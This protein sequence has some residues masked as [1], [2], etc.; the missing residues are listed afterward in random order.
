VEGAGKAC[1]S[2][3]VVATTVGIGIDESHLYL[4]P[5][6]LWPNPVNEV[7]MV[8]GELDTPK[9]LT[10]EIVNSMGQ[11]M[12]ISKRISFMAGS[13]QIPIQVSELPRGV[14]FIRAVSAQNQTVTQSFI[15]K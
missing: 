14:Y 5:L 12:L 4:S 15:K 1:S 6:L 9:E 2:D 11:R 7:L 8:E 10:F 3:R 13:F